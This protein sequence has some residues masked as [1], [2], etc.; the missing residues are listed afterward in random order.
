MSLAQDGLIGGLARQ[1]G[2]RSAQCWF[3]KRTRLVNIVAGVAEAAKSILVLGEPPV[4]PDV[5]L[6][7]GQSACRGV[8]E[9][10]GNAR[11]IGQGI[12]VDQVLPDRV[13]SV[14]RDDVP[15][16][17]RALES[18]IRQRHLGER[19]INLLRS[20][21]EIPFSEGRGRYSAHVSQTL[22]CPRTLIVGKEEGLRV[23][24]ACQGPPS[25]PPNWFILKPGS[26]WSKKFRASRAELRR[27]SNRS[28]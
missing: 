11:Q 24:L 10:V 2:Y 3:W 9:V 12:Q 26:F 5:E 6:V 18:S 21:G 19:V 22:V 16:E 20:N 13:D 28:P 8:E 4:D 17:L 27:N 15:W 25:V 23:L 14:G 7:L 1:T